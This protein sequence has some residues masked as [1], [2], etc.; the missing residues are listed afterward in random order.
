[1]WS[2]EGTFRYALSPNSLQLSGS[3]IRCSLD[4]RELGWLRRRAMASAL[5]NRWAL[6]CASLSLLN[7]VLLPFGEM[8]A[9]SFVASHAITQIVLIGIAGF[10][11]VL[12]SLIW[13]ST[14]RWAMPGLLLQMDRCGCCGMKLDSRRRVDGAMPTASLTSRCSE[15]GTDWSSG[16]RVGFVVGQLEHICN[17]A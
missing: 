14:Y 6:C 3:D 5:A 9:H 15:C 16:N 11:L 12:A 2:V 17:A 7:L 8:I 4:A 1:M 10:F 13:R